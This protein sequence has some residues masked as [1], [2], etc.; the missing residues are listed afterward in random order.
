MNAI[1]NSPFPVWAIAAVTA[2][3][4]ITR[5]FRLPEAI[6]AVLGALTLCVSGRLPWLEALHA[7][8]KGTDV[9][10]FLTGMMLASELARREGL[11]D[12]MAVLA[13][14][15]AN[16]SATRLF[17]LLYCVGTV[18]TILMSNDATAVVLTPA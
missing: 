15:K 10:L 5:P 14:R 7:V 12:Y 18:V 4:V 3:G 11:F 8:G 6:W 9:Y 1:L 2:L 16:G 17:F 13:A